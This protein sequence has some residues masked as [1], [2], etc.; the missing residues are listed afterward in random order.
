MNSV[1]ETAVG[2][3]LTQLNFLQ[4]REYESILA[5]IRLPLSCVEC[6]ARFAGTG[7]IRGASRVG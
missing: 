4:Y 2:L 7:G 1:R 5:R 3:F 6:I